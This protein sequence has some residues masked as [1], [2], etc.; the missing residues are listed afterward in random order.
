[1]IDGKQ[2][3]DGDLIQKNDDKLR[4]G[5]TSTIA[6]KSEQYLSIIEPHVRDGKDI[7][8]IAFLLV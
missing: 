6:I 3:I 2:Y 8:V 7:L 4:A 1:M 5:G